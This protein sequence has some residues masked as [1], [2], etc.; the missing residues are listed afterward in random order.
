MEHAAYDRQ[1]WSERDEGER[2]QMHGFR[3]RQQQRMRRR[4]PRL[5][6]TEQDR[7]AI[8]FMLSNINKAY[9]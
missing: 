3:Q 9:F 6:R 8:N 7:R 2:E 5:R 4:Q 1:W